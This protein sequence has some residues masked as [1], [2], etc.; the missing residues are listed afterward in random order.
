M[1]E[2]R[3]AKGMISDGHRASER[4]E[5]TIEQ[6]GEAMGNGLSDARAGEMIFEAIAPTFTVAN[7]FK[8]HGR[9]WAAGAPVSRKDD[10]APH[11]FDDL[12]DRGFIAAS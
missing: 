4:F 5:R 9:R 1:K 8:T 3:L 6:I 10:L 12:L 2:S 11:S 7:P